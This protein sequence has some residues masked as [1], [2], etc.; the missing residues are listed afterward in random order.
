MSRKRA[1]LGKLAPI[2][3]ILVVVL[4]AS[5]PQ[6]YATL[7]VRRRGNTTKVVYE[8]NFEDI[9]K[10]DAD[11]LN[12]PIDNSFNLGGGA[13][14][15][16]WMEGLD[17]TTPG[18]TCHSGIRCVGME[19]TDKT[20]SERNQFNILNLQNLVGQELFV[21]VWLY[22]PADWGLHMPFDNWYEIADAY[23]APPYNQYAAFH[24]D[25]PDG[26]KDVF[27][28]LLVGRENQD[29]SV[30]HVY[31]QDSN[32][33]LPRGRWFNLQYYVFRD[34][35]NGIIRIWIDGTLLFDSNNTPTKDPSVTE[36]FTIPA[37]IYYDGGDTYSPYRIWVDDLEIQ[38]GLS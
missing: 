23:S 37:K 21:S 31:M 34:A 5:I 33:P 32:Y 26:S 20:K 25:Q 6:A 3:I 27:N 18:I 7:V 19:L 17:R 9:A 30:L 29:P 24:I 14:A 2:L 22:L 1:A 16:F 28:L 13:G 4:A 15:A 11:S 38:D 35:T 8:T 12:M 10:R 36:W